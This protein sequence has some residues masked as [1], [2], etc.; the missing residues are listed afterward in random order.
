MLNILALFSVYREA[1]IGNKNCDGIWT[2][3]ASQTPNN[4]KNKSL[5]MTFKY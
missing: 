5:E 4:A 1:L 3:N 2:Q